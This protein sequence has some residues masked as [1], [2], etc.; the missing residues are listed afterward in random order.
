MAKLINR[1]TDK[2]RR[3][4]AEGKKWL[5]TVTQVK[6]RATSYLRESANH[7][8]GRSLDV[9]P[10]PMIEAVKGDYGTFAP[11]PFDPLLPNRSNFLSHLISNLPTAPKGLGIFIETDHVHLQIMKTPTMSPVLARWP[12][13]K[14]HCFHNAT[15]D[16]ELGRSGPDGPKPNYVIDP[17]MPPF[18]GVDADGKIWS[19]DELLNNI[20]PNQ[21]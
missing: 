14:D 21:G 3:T 9:A 19:K 10:L 7:K 11:R 15:E 6:W 13:P 2:M 5:E 12:G 8:E 1:S 16:S 20:H 4:L 18:S 17:V